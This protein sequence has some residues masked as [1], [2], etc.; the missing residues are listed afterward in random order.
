MHRFKE[1]GIIICLLAVILTGCG[2]GSRSVSAVTDRVWEYAQSHPEGFTLDISSW[3]EPKEGI[4]V[5]YAATQDS[6]SKKALKAVVR[7]ARRHDGY[8]GGWL[9]QDSGLYYF[10][11]TRL[12]PEDQPDSA[13]AFAIS[14]GQMSAFVISTGTE[15]R[16]GE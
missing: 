10:D 1:Q 5:S 16:L 7:H 12:F 6:Y 11:S 4:A 13:I 14:N 3:E 9:E 8:V 2:D 15:I